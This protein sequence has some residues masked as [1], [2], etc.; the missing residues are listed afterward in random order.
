[1]AGRPPRRVLGS[2]YII[3]KEGAM[4]MSMLSAKDLTLDLLIRYSFQLLGALF[5]LGIGALLARWGGNAMA[6]WLEARRMEPP[7]RTLIVRMVRLVILI[8]T[9]VVALDKFGFQIA[10]LVAGIGVA[11][12][13][14]G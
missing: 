13:G 4:P 14:I 1:M 5:I 8:F 2:P 6:T 3:S 10:P 11:G 7:V 12:L 9:L